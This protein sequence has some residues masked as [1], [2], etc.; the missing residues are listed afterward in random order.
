M[1]ASAQLFGQT[2][3]FGQEKGQGEERTDDEKDEN[4]QVIGKFN[5]NPSPVKEIQSELDGI[6]QGFGILNEKN[7]AYEEKKNQGENF[8]V[9]HV[10]SW[11]MELFPAVVSWI[12][13]V[14]NRV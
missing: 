12:R 14:G 8:E 2:D 4:E 7:H 9:A 3:L 11:V 10:S 6:G 13:A 5:G 1:I